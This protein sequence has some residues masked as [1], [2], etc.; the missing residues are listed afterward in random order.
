MLITFRIY[1]A[2]ARDSDMNLAFTGLQRSEYYKKFY[3]IDRIA[4]DKI[5]RN[6][7]VP[8]HEV[9]VSVNRNRAGLICAIRA[10][11]SDHIGRPDKTQQTNAIGTLF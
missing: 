10:L 6:S 1:A 9:L 2:D 4:C 8:S 3:P 7:A 11:G 5:N